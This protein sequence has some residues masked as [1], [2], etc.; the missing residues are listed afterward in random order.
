MSYRTDLVINS[1]LMDQIQ[2]TLL[3]PP[4][5]FCITTQ[6]TS[7]T[8]RSRCWVTPTAFLMKTC[9]S[10]LQRTLCPL[11]TRWDNLSIQEE[12]EALSSSVTW[13]VE[14][15]IFIAKKRYIYHIFHNY[16]NSAVPF[17]CQTLL[18]STK[19]ELALAYQCEEKLSAKTLIGCIH[20]NGKN[21][22]LR[23][24]TLGRIIIIPHHCS[25]A[26]LISGIFKG[27]P[28]GSELQWGDW[29][30]HEFQLWPAL[31]PKKKI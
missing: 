31:S 27:M 2:I 23:I 7:P 4:T 26:P 24:K 16:L 30:A 1:R 6:W 21:N 10:P 29:A 12:F 8:T 3:T 17:F 14:C 9:G 28:T 15:P 19:V 22:G 20:Q 11:S 25:L 13:V 5:M 18:H